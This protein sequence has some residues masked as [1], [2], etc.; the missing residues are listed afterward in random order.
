MLMPITNFMT[1]YY[2]KEKRYPGTIPVQFLKTRNPFIIILLAAAVLLNS[3]QEKTTI[4]GSDILPETDFST[5][6]GTDTIKVISYTVFGDSMQTN[7]KTYSY[8]GG[9][10]NPYFGNVRTDF[11]A[12]LRLNRKWAGKGQFVVDS[13]KLNFSVEGAKGDL[14]TD[15]WLE[16]SEI[17]E[18]LSSDSS[19]F[20]GRDPKV[21]KH[22]AT[23]HL[24]A[25]TKDTITTFLVPLPNTLGQYLTRDTI[26]LNQEDPATDFRS[27]FKGI[28]LTIV[29]QVPVK[30]FSSPLLMALQF[31][32]ADLIIKVYYHYTS[33]GTSSSYDFVIN[34]NS[35]RYNRYSYDYSTAEPDKK[36][37]SIGESYRDTLTYL[38]AFHG[39]RTRF[40][41]PGLDYYKTLGS[42]SVNK[43]KLTI[44]P[45]LDDSLFTATSI[46]PRIIISYK[47]NDG[48]K[49]VVPDYI[50]SPNFFD[51]TFNSAKG[52]YSFNISSFVQEYIEGRIADSELEMYLPEGE[53]KN[54]ILKANGASKTAKLD[55][56]FTRF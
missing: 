44:T 22:L 20:S 45:F 40:K 52:S 34:E 24:P 3:C 47:G 41:V 10:Y 54:V 2:Y 43:A 38:Q 46:P 4:I 8:L 39:I 17:G 13:V 11:V 26:R 27:F 32:T 42:V 56:V 12:Q 31:Q 6:S 35:V 30:S 49:Y 1:N 21:I 36:I 7:N 28:Y 37:N 48:I 25:I 16:L 29:E 5:V 50:I 14:S 18:E 33:D 15:L 53:Y 19:Y 23:V 51:G 9:L 55:F